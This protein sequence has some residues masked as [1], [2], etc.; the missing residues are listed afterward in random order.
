MVPVI[1]CGILHNTATDT[2]HPILYRDSP[3]PG[4]VTHPR[5]LRSIGHHTKGFSTLEEA[6]RYLQNDERTQNSCLLDGKATAYSRQGKIGATSFSLD[7]KS[8]I[9]F[10]PE[11]GSTSR[12][13]WSVS[14]DG[15]FLTISNPV[16]GRRLFER[17]GNNKEFGEVNPDH[18]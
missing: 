3:L 17:V 11:T 12:T 1:A 6:L 4:G 5:R 9:L 16:T 7:G 14:D 10:N 2:Y 8:L 13:E 18:R 15:R